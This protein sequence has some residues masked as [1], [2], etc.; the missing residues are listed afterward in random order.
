[1]HPALVQIT[2]RPMLC[3]AVVA[4]A[5]GLFL[6]KTLALPTFDHPEQQPVV[7]IADNDSYDNGPAP[8]MTAS[9]WMAA[10]A[11]VPITPAR[12]EAE[13]APSL[14]AFTA[15]V[16]PPAPAPVRA[17]KIATAPTP[18]ETP[19][20]AMPA[21]PDWPS[22]SGDITALPSPPEPPPAPPEPPAA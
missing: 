1:M 20:P 5:A 21:T 16:S 6:G 11:P 3:G 8:S 4:A 15:E 9:A 7:Q 22:A 14:E 19:P 2:S 18:A 10:N 17:V 12:W 13:S